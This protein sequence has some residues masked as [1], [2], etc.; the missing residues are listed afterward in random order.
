V[1]HVPHAATPALGA[2]PVA[3]TRTTTGGLR[4]THV[5]QADVA[6]LRVR[7]AGSGDPLTLLLP[8]RTGPPSRPAVFSRLGRLHARHWALVWSAR[9]PP[10]T[11]V[12]FSSGELRLCRESRSPAVAGGAAWVPVADG[13]YR[14]AT[15]DPDGPAPR[16]LPLA[17]SW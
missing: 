2:R 11:G 14:E 9:E 5:V 12:V 10:A 13:T 17:A 7:G 16:W 8:T 15:V 4:L 6:Y 3:D 1:A